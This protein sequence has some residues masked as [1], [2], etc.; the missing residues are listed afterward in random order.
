[1]LLD[2][3]GYWTVRRI[4]SAPFWSTGEEALVVAQAFSGVF[5]DS[6]SH[7]NAPLIL[8]A[9]FAA[10][11]NQWDRL[12]EQWRAIL[13]R[14]GLPYFHMVDCEAGEPPFDRKD[15]NRA[16]R[17]SLIHDLR[18]TIF[19]AGLFGIACGVPYAQWEQVITPD[20]AEWVGAPGTVCLTIVQAS[21]LARAERLGWRKPIANIF[22]AGVSNDALASIKWTSDILNEDKGRSDRIGIAKVKDTP[23]LQA[24][25]MFAWELQND[26]KNYLKRGPARPI[27]PHFKPWWNDAN[28]RWDVQFLEADVVRHRLMQPDF[29]NLLN[30]RRWNAD[31]S[32]KASEP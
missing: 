23:A 3:H 12:D 15:P 11:D 22:D 16:W 5:D 4:L 21:T 1:M 30:D 29:Q 31:G 7:K 14:E 28:H 19:S 2:E 9:G 10:F 13:R 27:R 24:A 18:E 20:V 6:N 17:D 8:W 26:M 32:P 25:D